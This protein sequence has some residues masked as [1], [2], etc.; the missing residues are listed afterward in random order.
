MSKRVGALARVQW[1]APALQDLLTVT[2]YIKTDNPAAAHRF[3]SQIKAKVS[4]LARFPHSGRGV[5][6]CPASGL[7]EIIVGDYRIIYRVV[8]DTQRVEILTV[9]HG[10]KPLE[11]QPPRQ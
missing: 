6:E 1:T 10:A 3:G 5:P 9:R 4:R 11:D 8:P 2:H 7:R